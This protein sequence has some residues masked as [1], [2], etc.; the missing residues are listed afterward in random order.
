MSNVLVH[1]A[2]GFDQPVEL[3]SACH[4][5]IEAQLETLRRLVSWLPEFGADREAARAAQAI[6][7]YFRTAALNHHQDEELDVFP[8]LLERAGEAERHQVQGLVRS[9]IADHRELAAAWAS[10]EAQLDQVAAGNTVEL[11]A[12]EVRCFLQQYRNHIDCEESM[13][14]PYVRRLLTADDEAELGA[15]MAARRTHS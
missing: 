6:L 2:P 3:L 11:D 13:L 15:S 14:L 12:E 8:R 9:L 1:P 10:I 7:R 4:G 5:R